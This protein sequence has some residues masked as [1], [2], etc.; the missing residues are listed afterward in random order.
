MGSLN[1]Q[2]LI[3]KVGK[4][5]ELKT[6]ASGTKYLFLSV[7]TSDYA[8]KGE[9]GKGKYDTTWHDVSVFGQTAEYVAKYA[10]KGSTVYVDGRTQKTKKEGT[11]EYN[12][13]VVA[14]TILV[15]GEGTGGHSASTE[16]EEPGKKTAHKKSPVPVSEQPASQNVAD[17]SSSDSEDLP[18]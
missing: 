18:F 4:D 17:T 12:T 2:E 6:S 11:N 7:A 16:D 10:K 14:N 1:R 8:G 5:V 3:G 15:I 9:D 13:R